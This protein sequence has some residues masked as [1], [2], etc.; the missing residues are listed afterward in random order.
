MKT[1]LALALLALIGAL[2]CGPSFQLNT[3]PGFVELDDD[4]AYD[5]RATT[6]DGLVI[7]VR[8]IDHEP[9]GELSF[10]VQAIQNRMRDRG[11]YALLETRS[12][13]SADGVAGKQ[14]RFGHDEQGNRPYLYYVAVFVTDSTIYLVEAGGTKEQMTKQAAQIDAVLRGFRTE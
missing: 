12:V 1:T 4:S 13:Q 9:E 7:G 14:L 5:Y 10:W 8:E 6:A 3:P 11:G 2:G